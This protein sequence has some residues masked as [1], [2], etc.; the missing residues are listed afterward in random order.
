[1]AYADS[2]I[3]YTWSVERFIPS[4]GLLVAKYTSNASDSFS[5]Y[6]EPQFARFTLTTDQYDSTSVAS[7][8]TDN[9]RNIVSAWDQAI[10]KSTAADSAGINVLDIINLTASDR[11]KPT[12]FGTPNVPFVDYNPLTFKDSASTSED[13]YAITTSYAVVALDS[14]GKVTARSQTAIEV[15]TLLTAVSNNTAAMAALGFETTTG[16]HVVAHTSFDAS[17][18]AGFNYTN[19]KFDDFGVDS[20]SRLGTGE[21]K[22][23]FSEPMPNANF[24][25]ITGVGDQDYGGAG[26]S[27]RQVAVIARDSSSVTILCERTDDAVNEDNAYMSVAVLG[28][29]G[30]DSVTATFGEVTARNLQYLSAVDEIAFGEAGLTRVQSALGYND[31]DFAQWMLDNGG[32]WS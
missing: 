23:T 24:T 4:T 22:V 15:K 10:E 6:R 27:P 20:V 7:V 21:F 5:A 31:S 12:V 9:A 17:A 2:A 26:A 30:G 25:A 28:S 13:S 18:G 8:I 3:D 16:S 1:M 14:A 11:Y 32:T 29:Y 19:D